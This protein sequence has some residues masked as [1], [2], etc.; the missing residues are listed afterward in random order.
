MRC[1]MAVM[2]QKDLFSG[3][4]M[5]KAGIAGILHFARC[6]PFCC[7]QALMPCITS[8]MDQSAWMV[9]LLVVH[10]P[11][12]CNDICLWFRLQKTVQAPQLQ[13]GLNVVVDFFCRGAEAVPLDPDCSEHHRDSPAAVH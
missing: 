7:S 11:V 10:T 9:F 12:V 3:S 6:I 1:I 2:D 5:C 8:G 13:Y 4:G